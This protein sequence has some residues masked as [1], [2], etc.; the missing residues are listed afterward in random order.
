MSTEW[1]REPLL[2]SPHGNDAASFAHLYVTTEHTHTYT[3]T[4]SLMF[5]KHLHTAVCRCIALYSFR[6]HH[7]AKIYDDKT[8]KRKP[9]FM[10][11]SICFSTH[12][13]SISFSMFS[14][15][16]RVFRALRLDACAYTIT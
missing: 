15:F 8:N 7:H 4:H 13:S 1:N 2:L 10:D 6:R 3:R 11:Y 16:Q 12:S 14:I 9:L 5:L